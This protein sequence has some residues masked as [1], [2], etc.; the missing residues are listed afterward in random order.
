MLTRDIQILGVLPLC[1]CMS[2]VSAVHICQFHLLTEVCLLIWLTGMGR[3]IRRGLGGI[4]LLKWSP[5][6]DYFLAAKLYYHL[7]C[8]FLSFVPVS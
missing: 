7:P 1:S 8:V 5:S 3:P 6:G 2:G 4:S